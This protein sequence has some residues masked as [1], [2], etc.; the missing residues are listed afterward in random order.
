MSRRRN[1]F[2]GVMEVNKDGSNAMKI[3]QVKRGI[4][5]KKQRFVWLVGWL[6]GCGW[7]DGWLVCMGWFVDW[8]GVDLG[9]V[10]WVG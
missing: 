6:V 2:N 4:F 1:R 10:G 5:P 9:W 3:V 8:V 7:L